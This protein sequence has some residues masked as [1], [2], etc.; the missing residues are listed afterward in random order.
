MEHTETAFR[1]AEKS[2]QTHERPGKPPLGRSAQRGDRRDSVA[3]EARAE[4]TEYY[5][6]PDFANAMVTALATCRPNSNASM[7][8]A[9]TR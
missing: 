8:S 5:G 3:N 7:N 4:M 1:L 2:W 9:P 6:N